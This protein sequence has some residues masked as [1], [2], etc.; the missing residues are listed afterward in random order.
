MGAR[1]RLRAEK[2]KDE[3]KQIAVAQLNDSKILPDKDGMIS[4]PEQPG[5]GVSFSPSAISKYLVD[6]E[7]V[8]NKKTLYRTPTI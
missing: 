3:K 8:V 5:V 2:L 4:V 7:I 6:V 1:K